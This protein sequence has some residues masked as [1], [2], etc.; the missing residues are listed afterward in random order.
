MLAGRGNENSV[1]HVENQLDVVGWR[2]HVV[3]IQI[4]KHEENHFHPEPRHPACYEW[5]WLIGRM[6]RT[7]GHTGRKKL[8]WRGTMGN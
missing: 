5:M 6:L 2:R 7:S 1:V 3:D 4:E 8:L